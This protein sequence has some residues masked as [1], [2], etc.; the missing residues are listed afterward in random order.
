MNYLDFDLL[1]ERAGNAYRAKVVKSPDGESAYKKFVMPFSEMELENLLLKIGWSKRGVRRV[2]SPDMDAAKKLGSRLF[3]T[4]F[5]GQA[6]TLLDSGLV[7]AREQGAGLRLRLRLTD[8][9]RLANLP[10]EFLYNAAANNFFG[11]S[12][13]TPV[14]RYMDM[15]GYI[16]PLKVEPPLRVLVMIAS[17]SNYPE[18][19]VDLEWENL[20]ASLLDLEQSGMVRLECLS[21]ATLSTLRRR[22]QQAQQAGQ[23]YHIFHFIGHGGLDPQTQDGVLLM[24][25]E[26]GRDHQVSGQALSVLLRN[27]DQLRLVI[28]NACEGAIGGSDDPFTGTAQ[29][30]VQQAIPAVIAMQFEI[31]DEAAV[32]FSREFYMALAG[33]SPVDAS[34]A[35]ARIAM[36]TDGHIMEWGTPVLYL[37]SPDGQIFDVAARPPQPE[38]GPELEPEQ[39]TSPPL[40]LSPPEGP[41]DP[42][43]LFYVERAA[44]Y[45]REI[46]KTGKG[47]TIA[48]KGPRQVGKT[49]FMLRLLESAHN[50]GKCV[51]L[52]NLREIDERYFADHEHFFFIFCEMI[53]RSLKL[54]NRVR[55]FWDDQPYIQRC[56]YYMGEYVLAELGR[57]LVLALDDVEHLFRQDYASDFFG[58]LRGWHNR[59]AF[60]TAP[61]WKQLDLVIATSADPHYFIKNRWQSP[62]NV[63][64]PKIV[65]GEFTVDE[66]SDLDGRYGRPLDAQRLSRLMELTAGHPYLTHFGL[67]SVASRRNSA[68]DLFRPVSDARNPYRD[69]LFNVLFQRLQNEPETLAALRVVLRDNRCDDFNMALYLE[70]A[71]LVRR[72]GKRFTMR[73]RLYEDFCGE[74]LNV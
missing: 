64:S 6:Q 44:D 1:I 2:D 69:Y 12:Q 43:S 51:A 23:G 37:R 72:E 40:V 61:I 18:L 9:P 7:T 71:G 60:F 42:Q 14:V 54:R 16:Q 30:L 53:T 73:C 11:L 41:I 8:A 39:P 35:A 33:G 74:V 66:V 15:P 21:G 4:V 70:G 67:Y 68:D 20:H 13:R 59:R 56:T 36:F 46:E 27:H 31:T 3:E 50:A 65:L 29:S 17:P 25:D 5:E 45:V 55:E 48:I 63:A 58:M 47:M 28:L 26:H 57:P 34:V 52:L 32:A 49:S 24:E 22:L 38:P 62:F 10:W 19:K